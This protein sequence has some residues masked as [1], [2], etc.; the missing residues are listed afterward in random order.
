[1]EQSQR[2]F[3]ATAVIVPPVY[4]VIKVANMREWFSNYGFSFFDSGIEN[5]RKK[6]PKKKDILEII[7]R[8]DKIFR[9]TR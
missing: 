8:I 5:A 2:R 1:M 6:D 9:E 7:S 4:G 3:R